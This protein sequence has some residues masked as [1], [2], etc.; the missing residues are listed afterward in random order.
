MPG[1]GRQKSHFLFVPLD[2]F[3]TTMDRN[4]AI[5][6]GF[7]SGTSR[8]GSNTKLLQ[9]AP[10]IQPEFCRSLVQGR[11]SGSG[12]S[13]TSLEIKN[14]SLAVLLSRKDNAPFAV[15]KASGPEPVFLSHNHHATVC[16]NALSHFRGRNFNTSSSSR[17]S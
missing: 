14:V 10:G 17:V 15:L 4:S 11:L 13:E 16:L 1:E 7:S 9:H 12:D 6:L 5:G 3:S 2:G 8:N